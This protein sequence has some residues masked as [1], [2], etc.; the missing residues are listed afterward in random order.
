MVI[1][2]TTRKNYF[3]NFIIY[4][5]LLRKKRPI[6][7]IIIVKR[8]TMKYGHMGVWQN[9]S[10]EDTS[11]QF[12]RL[13]AKLILLPGH[14]VITFFSPECS[15]VRINVISLINGFV[16]M[17]LDTHVEAFAMCSGYTRITDQKNIKV[18]WILHDDWIHKIIL[19]LRRV[20]CGYSNQSL[21]LLGD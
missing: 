8:F 16:Q 21:W 9:S 7:I 13:Y 2:N 14:Q 1:Y 3:F 5:Y 12:G 17:V 6:S 11:T 15:V 10:D 19:W 18:F 4:S 20:E